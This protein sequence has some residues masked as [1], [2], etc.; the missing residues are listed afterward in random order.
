MD[1]SSWDRGDPAATPAE[2][3]SDS[4]DSVT[5]AD[6][7][8][9]DAVL[10][11]EPYDR[12]TVT[13]RGARDGPVAVRAALSDVATHHLDAGPVDLLGDLG[14]VDIPFGAP[15]ATAREAVRETV[16]AVHESDTIPVILG[17]DSSLTV[18]NVA[19]LLATET[20]TDGGER[21]SSDLRSDGGEQTDGLGGSSDLR[22]DGGFGDDE[23][24]GDVEHFDPAGGSDETDEGDSDPNAATE[25]ETESSTDEETTDDEAEEKADVDTDDA[26]ADDAE[27]EDDE[28]SE[29]AAE[30]EEETDA[31]AD[32]E[33]EETAEP[34]EEAATDDDTEEE[35]DDEAE[36]ATQEDDAD[37]DAE[38]DDGAETGDT[39]ETG[40]EEVVDDSG[41]GETG[42]GTSQSATEVVEETTETTV[43]TETGAPETTSTDPSEST[44]SVGVIRLGSRLDCQP[45]GSEPT[46]RSVG[47]Q[48]FDAGVDALAVVGARHFES[49]TAEAEYL[50]EQGGE[51]VTAE[52]VGADP[53]EAAD[54]ALETVTDADT[55]YLSIDLSVLDSTAAPGVSAPAPGGLQTRELFQVLRLLANDERLAGLELVETAPTHDRDGQTVD[56]AARAVAHALAAL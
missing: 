3:F 26:E 49:T 34:D 23:T 20:A 30:A 2:Q 29:G 33:T 19:G 56:A 42:F 43:T 11:G 53:V 51:V 6:A 50:R 46:N 8:E 25:D 9:Y 55:L 44:E 18:A 27:A 5:A 52:E 39:E 32:E 12:G 13:R 22:S 40:S 7:D 15:V 54:R 37:E 21:P 17:G 4:I 31:E 24:V 10:V 38:S 14:S 35:A 28:E 47:R 45:V 48:L 41:V 16:D 36:D 1:R